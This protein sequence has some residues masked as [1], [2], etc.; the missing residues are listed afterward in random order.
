MHLQEF[1]GDLV[2]IALWPSFKL[3]DCWGDL[4]ERSLRVEQ[5]KPTRKSPCVQLRT[6]ILSE[7]Q[8]VGRSPLSSVLTAAIAGRHPL[9]PR[10]RT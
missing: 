9:A 2:L 3:L 6:N 1:A 4:V 5:A 7:H 8:P 10:Q